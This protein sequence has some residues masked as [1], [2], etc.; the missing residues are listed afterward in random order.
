MPAPD[1][2]EIDESVGI[3]PHSYHY[4]RVVQINGR[5]VRVRIRRDISAHHSFA[6]SEVL[7][8]KR[9]WTHLTEDCPANWITT[10]PPPSPAI[11]APTV[12]GGL[13]QRL[14]HRSAEILTVPP[15]NDQPPTARQSH[16]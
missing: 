14:I 11:I 2:N 10:T 5:T 13:A 7:T 9:T 6:V 1:I 15:D 16:H 12:L 3:T 8:E 4:I